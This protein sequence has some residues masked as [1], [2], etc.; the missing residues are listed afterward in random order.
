MEVK[1]ELKYAR[2]APRKVRLVA[3]L[4]RGMSARRAQL[5]LAH[6][7][8]RASGTLYKLLR[9]AVANATH[10]FALAED[11]LYVK[12]L[13]V[14]P[15]PMLKRS[16]ARAFGRAF[17]VR[18]RTSHVTILLG[19]SAPRREASP[20]AAEEKEPMIRE[21]LPEEAREAYEAR[22]KEEAR[23]VVRPRKVKPIEFVRRVFR[24]KAI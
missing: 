21:A 1:A 17:P 7:T 4:I 14:N 5:E 10:N 8:K 6:R 16:R 20:G 19:T 22:P 3:N 23:E 9:S 11:D 13:R 18:K 15:G 24:R 12:E 2:I